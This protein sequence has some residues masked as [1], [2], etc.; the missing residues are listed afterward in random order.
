MCGR[1]HSKA[2]LQYYPRI[3]FEELRQTV[4]LLRTAGLKSQDLKRCHLS[5]KHGTHP[6][7][8]EHR[9]CA[10]FKFYIWTRDVEKRTRSEIFLDSIS[11]G[12]YVQFLN[13]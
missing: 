7:D 8:H 13:C 4:T 5:V 10:C 6:L 9:V 3:C 12:I 2:S 11:S 1:I